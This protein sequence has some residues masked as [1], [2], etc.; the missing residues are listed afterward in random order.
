MK[1]LVIG[2]T[3][4][5]GSHIVQA[6][7]GKG[8]RVRIPVRH[9]GEVA[10]CNRDGGVDIEYCYGDV[11]DEGSLRACMDGI[12]IVYG[13]FGL[14]GQWRISHDEY[15]K[16]N[17]RAVTNVLNSLAGTSVRQFIHLS[18]AGVLGPLPDGVI[19]DEAFPFNPS[20]IYEMSK[21]EAEREVLRFGKSGHL[22]FTIVRPEFV[23][24]PG[25]L[26]VLPLFSAIRKRRFFLIGN[27]ASVLHPTY[28]DDLI[29]GILLCADNNRAI[30]KTYMITGKA[31]LHVREIAEIIAEELNVH[32]S[33][34]NIPRGFAW[35]GASALELLARSIRASK[36][37]LTRSQVKFFSENRAFSNRKAQIELGYVPT[38]DFREGVKRTLCWY[39]EKEYL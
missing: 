7:L 3:G 5:I 22:P 36:P 8:V 16:V 13:S 32:L 12:E 11:L 4:F 9:K 35:L 19:A 37:L 15:W 23:Y 21:C 24:G 38:V 20:N 39:T 29:Q 30:G 18:S 2:G 31:P 17:T 28:I 33:R 27:G 10:G 1:A 34:I 14:L 25:D 26:H 6:L